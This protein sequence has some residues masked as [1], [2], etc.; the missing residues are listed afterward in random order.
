[1]R[2]PQPPDNPVYLRSWLRDVFRFLGRGPIERLGQV[3]IAHPDGVRAF[4]D[5]VNKISTGS[6][7]EV[8]VGPGNL[9]Y[10]IARKRSVVGIEIDP[11]LAWIASEIIMDLPASII[12]GDGPR[13]LESIRVKGV[14]SN[15]PYKETSRIIASSARNNE[16]SDM[17]LGVQLE[18]AERI[19]AEPGTPNYG[20]L[21]LLVNRYFITREITKLPKN[22]FYPEP[23]VHGSLLWFKRIR[24][25][26]P[27]DECFEKLTACLFTGRN[28]LAD[29]MA[30]RCIGVER[31]MLS[32][33]HGKR[34]RDLTVDDIEW[35]MGL[36]DCLK[37]H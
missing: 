1:M 14:Y 27:G 10:Y 21:T 19:L 12:Y 22:W 23:E 8:G 2:V 7:V 31:S 13:I 11:K 37:H 9:L 35:L 4:V 32:K 36:G 28:K 20:R 6:L 33:V 25:W 3:F 15:T 24:R 18:V 29:K 16:I 30:A 26:N 34:V 5:A 17:V